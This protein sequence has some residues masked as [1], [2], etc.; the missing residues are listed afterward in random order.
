MQSQ[1]GRCTHSSA[2]RF[3]L[4]QGLVSALPSVPHGVERL[5]NPSGYRERG[6][7]VLFLVL[8]EKS[9]T[10]ATKG[11]NFSAV[12]VPEQIEPVPGTSLMGVNG[13]QGPFCLPE[14]VCFAMI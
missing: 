2:L 6:T 12:C 8:W 3:I 7:D 4:P 10:I 14:T 11:S 13:S 5:Q 9:H 1:P